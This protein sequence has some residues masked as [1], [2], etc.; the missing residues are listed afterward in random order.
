MT[1]DVTVLVAIR[2]PSGPNKPCRRWPFVT[3]P[4]SDEVNHS[5][6]SRTSAKQRPECDSIFAG[7]L[8][9]RTS[10]R[11][12]VVIGRLVAFSGGFLTYKTAG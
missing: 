12:H 10:L 9:I 6:M 8:C 1:L 7:N 5:E 3:V 2:Q 4:A 11:S